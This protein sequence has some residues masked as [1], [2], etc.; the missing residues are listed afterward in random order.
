MSFTKVILLRNMEKYGTHFPYSLLGK[1][2]NEVN[3]IVSQ[4]NRHKVFYE[5]IFNIGQHA[6]GN[7]GEEFT[8]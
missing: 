8:G 4:H 3:R 6:S 2:I 7:S 1:G 5:W